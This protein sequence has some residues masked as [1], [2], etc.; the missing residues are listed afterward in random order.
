MPLPA[1]FPPVPQPPP[2]GVP[3]EDRAWAD[4]HAAL[5][6]WLARLAAVIP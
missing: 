6:V 1:G 2:P 5:T 3:F 4:Y